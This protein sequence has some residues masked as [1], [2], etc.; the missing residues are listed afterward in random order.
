MD[1]LTILQQILE[2][3][4][5]ID[6]IEQKINKIDLIEQ[7]IKDIK[8]EMKDINLKLDRNDVDKK[9][10]IKELSY[11]FSISSEIKEEVKEIKKELKNV[12]ELNNLNYRA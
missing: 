4:S 2:K 8:K 6:A 5:K 1:D 7:N 10:I 9:D 12:I 11:N 3:V